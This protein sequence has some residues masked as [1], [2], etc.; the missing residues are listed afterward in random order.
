MVVL[1]VFLAA[2]DVVVFEVA[3]VVVD[4]PLKAAA[5]V[6]L[7]DSLLCLPSYSISPAFVMSI[8]LSSPFI[9]LL[10]PI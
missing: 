10:N 6:L 4:H 7:P 9:M 3:M 5:V 1:L 2:V 8:F